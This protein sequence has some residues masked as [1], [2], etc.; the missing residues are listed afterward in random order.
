MRR[1]ARILAW[2]LCGIAVAVAV[3]AIGYLFVPPRSG[4]PAS[5]PSPL[6]VVSDALF[7]V[8]T[9]ILGAVIASRMPRNPIGWL[10]ILMSLGLVTGFATDGY[11]RHAPAGP[12]TAAVGVLGSSVGNV[13]FTALFLLL[14]LF[15]SGR[16]PSRR[17][18]WVMWLVVAGSLLQ[19]IYPL[20]T[21]QPLHP[22]IPD[23]PNP[24]AVP[25]IAAWVELAGTISTVLLGIALVGTIAA[26]VVR[27]RRARGVERQQLKWFAFA[28]GI[29]GS[30]LLLTIAASPIPHLSDVLWSIAFTLLP[31]LPISAAIA[32]LRHRL[33]DIDLVINRTL[34]YGAVSVVLGAIYIGSVIVIQAVLSRFT[35]SEGLAVAISTLA[36]A[37]LFQP[38]RRGIQRA[39]DRRF[40]RSRY[41]AARTVELFATRLRAEVDLLQLTDELASVVDQTLQP[42]SVSVWLRQSELRP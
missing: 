41:D 3:V 34:V 15:P 17:W 10:F 21:V 16:L 12:L 38:I 1:H 24:F 4:V 8:V 26:V 20:L 36:V 40:Y 39:V 5:N 14:L 11:A 37:A 27:F 7:V 23:A 25:S 30:V 9:P 2:L 13:G 31:L 28:S 42:A 32:I 35:S 22:P 29:L 6:Q 18:R 19:A 33:F